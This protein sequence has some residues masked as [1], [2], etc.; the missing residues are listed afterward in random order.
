MVSAP[1]PTWTLDV[2]FS[3][4]NGPQFEPLETCD[5]LHL[6]WKT[7]AHIFVATGR[8]AS[9]MPISP[10]I[11]SNGVMTVFYILNG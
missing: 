11:V 8:R 9:E 6:K 7:L 4:L 2:L 3:F 10:E 5:M 1:M